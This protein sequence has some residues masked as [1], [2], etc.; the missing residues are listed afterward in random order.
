[1]E[2][3]EVRALAAKG[4]FRQSQISGK[5]EETHI[6]W[7]ILSKGYVF[8]IK[9]PVKYSFLDFSTLSQRRIYCERELRLNRRFSNIYLDVLQVRL[10]KDT[11]YIGGNRGQ[12]MDYAVRMK[13]MMTA[14][15]MDIQLR[16][17]KVTPGKVRS[18]AKVIASSHQNAERVRI[19]FNQATARHTFNDIGTVK[20]LV[21]ENLGT[22]SDKILSASIHWS[23]TFLE[24]HAWRLRERIIEGFQRDVHGDFHSGNIFLYKQPVIF[25]CIEFNDRYRQIDVLYEIAFLC[26]DLEASQHPWLAEEFLSEYIR[27]FNC[28][29]KEADHAIFAYYK[30]LRANIRAKVHALRAAQGDAREK[31][32]HLSSVKKYLQQMKGYMA[33]H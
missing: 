10:A 14:K 8:K 5:I 23:N 13:R 24:K 25:D 29:Q 3:S 18:L 19:P 22:E 27:H 7:V 4:I 2:G 17:G 16:K 1:M 32:R 28:F 31:A 20:D 26:M 9:K 30:C 33:Q 11:W 15:R 12:I 21:K 6:S